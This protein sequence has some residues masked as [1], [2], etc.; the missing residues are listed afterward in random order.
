[1]K[2]WFPKE[3]EVDEDTKKLV[4]GRWGEYFPHEKA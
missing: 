3:L 4:D 2:P 1:M